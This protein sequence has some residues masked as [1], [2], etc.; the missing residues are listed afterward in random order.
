MRANHSKAAAPQNGAAALQKSRSPERKRSD[1]RR[2]AAGYVFL[3]PVILGILLF[4]LGPILYSLVVSFTD[5][6]FLQDA[7]FTWNNF[8]NYKD[9][10]AIPTFTKSIGF[11]FKYAF[12]SV[13]VSMFASFF[14]A[15]AL[16]KPSAIM[17]SASPVVHNINGLQNYRAVEALIAITGNYDVPGGNCLRA[18]A[19]APLNEFGRELRLT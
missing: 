11:T 1:L 6:V 4:T 5:Y 2:T 7:T 8:A 19:S 3:S 15:Y 9:M 16:N 13:P 18:R 14:L 10:F 17:F 12:V